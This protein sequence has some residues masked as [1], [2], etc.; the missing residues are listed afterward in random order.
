MVDHRCRALIGRLLAAALFVGVLVSAPA[1]AETPPIAAVNTADGVA[2]KG[3]DAVAYFITG[4]PTQGLA[5]YTHRWKGVTYRFA[6][7][8]NRER[9]KADPEKYLPQY[10]GYCAYAMSINRIADIDPARWAIVDG[11]LYLN[12]NRLSQV[13]WS[14]NKPGRITAGDRN[15]AVFPKTAEGQ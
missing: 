11:K 4:A 15:W 10:G 6:T 8:A 2:L 3:Y 14:V 7:A 9:F 1:R 12:N 13:L 5:E